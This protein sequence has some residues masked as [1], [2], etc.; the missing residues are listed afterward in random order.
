M[1]YLLSSCIRMES[2][3]AGDL[4]INIYNT[5]F[6]LLLD[7]QAIWRQGLC[8]LFL[9]TVLSWGPDT[10]QVISEYLLTRGRKKGKKLLQKAGT[11]ERERKSF[12]NTHIHKKTALGHSCK[13]RTSSP[14]LNSN[15]SKS[16]PY[17]ELSSNWGIGC[18]K[19]ENQQDRL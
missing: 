3:A 4:L 9:F 5:Y 10:K 2:Y 14:G 7:S 19:S 8:S 16:Y 6:Y 12:R 15:S 13:A 1:F 18:N 17:T 11:W